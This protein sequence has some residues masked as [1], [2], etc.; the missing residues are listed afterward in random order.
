M[1]MP[2]CSKCTIGEDRAPS[3][4]ITSRQRLAR[5]IVG[6]GWLS[7]AWVFLGVPIRAIAWPTVIIAVWFG[8]S[9]VV[10]GW[11]GYPD[12]PE[13]GAIASVLGRRYIS[14]RCGLWVALDRWLEP[15][16]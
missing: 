14:T 8:A 9:H 15:R 3:H 13:L 4:T 5:V 16:S 11:I 7:L 1:K 12:C 2:Y 6:L 10:A